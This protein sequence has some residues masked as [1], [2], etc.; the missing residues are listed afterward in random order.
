MSVSNS[1]GGEEGISGPRFPSRSLV[2]CPFQGRGLRV[3]PWSQVPG[4]MA[5]QAEGGVGRRVSWGISY[6]PSGTF[7]LLVLAF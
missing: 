3:S 4:L 7:G 1:V 2:P 6:W 5:F